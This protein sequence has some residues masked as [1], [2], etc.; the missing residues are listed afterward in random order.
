[1]RTLQLRIYSHML[2]ILVY[3]LGVA[4]R[5]FESIRKGIGE[6]EQQYSKRV[7]LHT[8]WWIE[9]PPKRIEFLRIRPRNFKR[10]AI[11]ID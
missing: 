11:N 2:F 6:T 1:M 10:A 9:T 5:D 3:G 8:V 4:G 7:L